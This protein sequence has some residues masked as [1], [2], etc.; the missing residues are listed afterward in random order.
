MS[1]RFIIF[2]SFVISVIMNASANS[3]RTD[4]LSCP[5]V[6]IS[7]T[8][9]NLK[10]IEWAYSINGTGI[11]AHKCKLPCWTEHEWDIMFTLAHTAMW[12]GLPLDLLVIITWTLNS[13]KRKQYFVLSF[14]TW[15]FIMQSSLVYSSFLTFE[16]AFCKYNGAVRI[17]PSDGF[18]SCNVQSFLGLMG[19]VGCC[20]SWMLQSIDLCLKLRHHQLLTKKMKP[21]NLILI[22][23]GPLFLGGIMI[24]SKSYG[25]LPGTTVCWAGGPWITYLAYFPFIIALLVGGPAAICV[26]MKIFFSFRTVVRSYRIRSLIFPK[27]D[28]SNPDSGKFALS[29]HNHNHNSNNQNDNHSNLTDNNNDIHNDDHLLN[30]LPMLRNTSLYQLSVQSANFRRSK[31]ALLFI[32]SFL[33]LIFPILVYRFYAYLYVHPGATFPMANMSPWV[34]CIFEH[35]DWKS[36][37]SWKSICGSYPPIRIPYALSLF[38]AL[39]THGTALLISSTYLIQPSVWKIWR[40]WWKA[41]KYCQFPE[42]VQGYLSKYSSSWKDQKVHGRSLLRLNSGNSAAMDRNSNATVGSRSLNNNNNTNQ[43]CS[44]HDKGEKSNIYQINN[45]SG[46]DESESNNNN[47]N[48]IFAYSTNT[49][50]TFKKLSIQWEN[51]DEEDEFDEKDKEN[52]KVK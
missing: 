19:L 21:Y 20:L 35:Y 22:I 39:T 14:A 1:W 45:N 16:E 37:D 4:F 3:T 46:R 2:H 41:M 18:H 8:D 24:L 49:P 52:L 50:T 23:G 7:P 34:Q 12:I 15:S 43:I 26:I 29:N 17:G 30:E 33:I 48:K 47:S 25:Y 32:I 51:I 36:D 13:R 42:S 5:S 9:T 44:N 11:C 28:L 38:H 27:T 10:G 31:G 6:F 40:G